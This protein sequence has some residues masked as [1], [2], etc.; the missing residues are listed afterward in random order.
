MSGRWP[1]LESM[2]ARDNQAGVRA[3]GIAHAQRALALA[4]LL[5]RARTGA[6][7]G[8]PPEQR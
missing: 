4:L 5:D 7:G 1:L 6:G 2:E 3:R 8:A